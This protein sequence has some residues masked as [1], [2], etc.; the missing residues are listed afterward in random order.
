MRHCGALQPED[1]FDALHATADDMSLCAFPSDAFPIDIGG[2]TAV[3]VPEVSDGP[4]GSDFDTG[5]GFIDA[6]A[7]FHRVVGGGALGPH[8]LLDHV[9]RLV[10][11]I[12]PAEIVQ[13]RI[14]G[15]HHKQGGD[16]RRRQAKGE[17]RGQ[18]N[19]DLRL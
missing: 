15:G 13:N 5:L 16:R 9:T 14:D 12:E 11:G 3:L 10:Q 1:Y 2:G 18:G 6:V 4:L 7:F 17:A 19:E 8:A